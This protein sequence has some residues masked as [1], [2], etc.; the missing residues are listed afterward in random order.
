MIVR[1]ESHVIR[2]C[3]DSVK[4]H[5][6]YWVIVDTGSEDETRELIRESLG[7]IPG[8]L[9]ERPWVD[10]G[11]NRTEAIA[12]AK[13]KCDYIFTIDADEVLIFKPG[14]DMSRLDK[15]LYQFVIRHEGSGI[16]YKRILLIKDR[17]NCWY[18][19]AI[20]EA[21]CCDRAITS[22]I[23]AGAVILS[24]T[25]GSR[26]KDPDKYRKDAAL[27][28]KGLEKDPANPRSIY[29]LAQS[30][31]NIPDLPKA[32]EA[33]QKRAAMGGSEEEVF[34]S[35]Y[36]I[37][38]IRKEINQPP[39]EEVIRSLMDAYQNR[40]ARVE[41]LYQIAK[42]YLTEKNYESAFLLLKR[43]LE[44]P[45]P[46]DTVFVQRW[47]YDWGLLCE[48]AEASLGLGRYKECQSAICALLGRDC[49]PEEVRKQLSEV[50]QNIIIC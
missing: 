13:G 20:H 25:K 7:S 12:L 21:I 45:M 50:F 30:Y 33:Y 41:P 38:M 27:L 46:E 47:I 3:L 2:N 15:D 22:S 37:A 11:H 16:D 9:H 43:A 44:I 26:S 48:Y 19:G 29:F 23:M 14:F 5:I 6:H 40:P 39:G 34:I 28:E 36:Q 8:E 18:E 42:I 49:L 17:C 32:L 10:F 1:N 31:L 4:K 35:L 24:N